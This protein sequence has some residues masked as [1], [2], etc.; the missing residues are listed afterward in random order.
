MKMRTG[1]IE[2]PLSEQIA[3][4]MQVHGYGW[5]LGAF[6]KAGLTVEEF[7]LLLQVEFNRHPEKSTLAHWVP[8]FN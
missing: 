7:H 5:T 6:L 4:T 8:A 2:Y 1:T 3:D